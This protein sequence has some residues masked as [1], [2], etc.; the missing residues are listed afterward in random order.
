M[1]YGAAGMASGTNICSSDRWKDTGVDGIII[2][3]MS[4]YSDIQGHEGQRA[5][6][7][8][9]SC[10]SS[11]TTDEEVNLGAVW[12]RAAKGEVEEKEGYTRER[13]AISRLIYRRARAIRARRTETKETSQLNRR[14]FLPFY[15]NG[16]YIS[17]LWNVS[18]EIGATVGVQTNSAYISRIF[19]GIALDILYLLWI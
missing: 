8:Y 1:G 16:I 10:N 9:A 2:F 11:G 19:P 3:I 18:H 13:L 15:F 7:F 4:R 17:C 12:K 14:M 6:F 5:Q